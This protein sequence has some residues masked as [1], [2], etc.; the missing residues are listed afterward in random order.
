MLQLR[1]L[2]E[3]CVWGPGCSFF[4]LIFLQQI[5]PEC[6]LTTKK[7]SQTTSTRDWT[8]CVWVWRNTHLPVGFFNDLHLFVAILLPQGPFPLRTSQELSGGILCFIASG[9]FCDERGISRMQQIK[10]RIAPGSSRLVHSVEGRLHLGG[11]TGL[12]PSTRT[13][14]LLRRFFCRGL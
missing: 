2:S 8:P 4:N 11:M 5:L 9:N 3:L 1:F 13:D 10:Q 6:S 7:K 12:R 14:L